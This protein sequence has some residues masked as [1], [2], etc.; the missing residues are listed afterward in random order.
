MASPITHNCQFLHI[1]MKSVWRSKL[2]TSA[3]GTGL[4]RAERGGT[5]DGLLFHFGTG[6]VERGTGYCS[7]FLER[8]TGYWNGGWNGGRVIVPLFWNR[9]G[10][11]WWNG[12]R[13]I[14]PLFWNRGH[15]HSN[16]QIWCRTAGVRGFWPYGL[17][18]N[19]SALTTIVSDHASKACAWRKLIYAD[20]NF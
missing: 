2:L 15:P 6:D 13:V 18:G 3:H 9:N 8:G 14:V 17:G 12:G 19:R 5:G 1:S 16:E 4:E 11:R 20:F 10:G 7:T